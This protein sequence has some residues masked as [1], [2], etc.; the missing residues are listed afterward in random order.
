MP[1]ISLYIDEETM[2]KVRHAAQRQHMSISKWFAEQ[3]QLRTEPVYP[4]GF[5]ELYGSVLED[6]IKRP[7][8][9]GFNEDSPRETL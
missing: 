9:T 4:M 1:Q 8:Q 6:D 7:M 5:E 3:I 2:K